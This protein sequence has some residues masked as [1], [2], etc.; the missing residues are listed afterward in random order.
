VQALEAEFGVVLL[1]RTNQGIIPTSFGDTLLTRATAIL[2][3]CERVT[4]D[5]RQ[6]E[7]DARGVVS[8]GTTV[9]PLTE[10]LMPVLERFSSRFPNVMVHL[11]SGSS[12][13][14]IERIRDGRLDFGLC[15]VAPRISDNDLQV[16]RLYPSDPGILARSNHPMAGARSIH[17]LVDCRWVGARFSSSWDPSANRLN[18]LFEAEGLGRPRIAVV[19]ESLLETLHIVAET[20]FLALEPRRLPEL[21]LFSNALVHIP[22]R[23]EIMQREVCL[24]RRSCAPPTLAAQ[25][26]ASMLCSYSRLRKSVPRTHLTEVDGVTD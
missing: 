16:E 20:N 3:D 23:E 12:D 9:E 17:E 18:R 10:L 6:L 15:V 19:A 5:L 11:A 2:Q 7:G 21:K 8:V 26:F 14:L 13:M 1:R 25:E 22:I 4:Q 24:V